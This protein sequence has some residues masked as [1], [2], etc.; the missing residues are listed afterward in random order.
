MTGFD[1]SV[2]RVTLNSYSITISGVALSRRPGDKPLVVRLHGDQMGDYITIRPSGA[3]E[4]GPA[5]VTLDVAGEYR[6]G[7]LA[8]IAQRKKERKGKRV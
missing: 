4:S 3:R 6:R 5:S 7:M 2:R 1:K 8:A